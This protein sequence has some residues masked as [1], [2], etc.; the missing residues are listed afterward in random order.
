MHTGIFHEKM[1]VANVI[2]VHKVCDTDSLANYKIISVFPILSKGLEKA[3]HSRLISFLD[4]HKRTLRPSVRVQEEGFQKFALLKEN[5]W[6]INAFDNKL[7]AL[8]S[9]ID[10]TK[11]FNN[12]NYD[13]LI[14][15][16][17]H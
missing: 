3:I 11:A 8:R 4:K 12:V 2:V 13:V 6:V 15:K 7:V 17:E 5:N 14:T 9:F 16:F 1:Q 10:W